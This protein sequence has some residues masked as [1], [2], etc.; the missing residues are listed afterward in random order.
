MTLLHEI[1]RLEPAEWSRPGA[2]LPVPS[3]TWRT[4]CRCGHLT[5][6]REQRSRAA[7]DGVRHCAAYAV[8]VAA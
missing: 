7:I 5:P 3:R 6:P 1:L 4:A 8:K 2:V